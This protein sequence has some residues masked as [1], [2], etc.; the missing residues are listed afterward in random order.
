MCATGPLT[1]LREVIDTVFSDSSDSQIPLRSVVVVASECPLSQLEGLK[2]SQSDNPRLKFIEEPIR[3]GKADAINRILE[4][5]TSEYLVLVNSDAHPEKGAVRKVLSTLAS[6]PTT[7]VVSASPFPLREGG[8]AQGLEEFMWDAHNQCSLTLNHLGVSNHSSD[9]LVA[10]RRKAVARLP[11]G[12]VNDGAFL[13]S[14]ARVRGYSVKF[15]FTAKVGVE[16]PRRISDAIGRRRRILFG[17]F[18]VWRKVGAQPKTLESL[19]TSRPVLGL[20]IVVQALAGHPKH[21]RV[22]PLAIL[23]EEIA[24]FFAIYDI[25]LSSKRHYIWR[26]PR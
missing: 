16:T 10:I 9:E 22:L 1:G 24:H 7:G 25:A 17:H 5:T 14:I 21:L 26:R 11:F 6:E 13:A 18:Q 8:P 19:L 23:S 12:L 15:C 2:N 3:K 20:K 4:N